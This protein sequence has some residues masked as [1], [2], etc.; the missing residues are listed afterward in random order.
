MKLKLKLFSF[1]MALSLVVGQLF[2]LGNLMVKAADNFSAK[3]IIESSC[4]VIV[5]DTASK[6]NAKDALS[7]VC[8]KHS[9]QLDIS[10]DGFINS[11]NNQAND[12]DKWTKYWM[13]AVNSNDSYPDIN[14]GIDKYTLKNGDKLIAYY[15]GPNTL[16]LNKIDFSTKLSNKPLTISLN[17]SAYGKVTPISNINVKLDGKAVTLS[18]NNIAINNG[19]SLGKHTLD[20]SDYKSDGMPGVVADSINFYFYPQAS[21]RVEGLNSTITTGSSQ[22]ANAEQIVENVLRSNNVSFLLNKYG[23]ISSI[24]NVAEKEYGDG[25]GWMYYVKSK[26]S[27]VSPDKGMLDYVP[28]DGD[29]IVVYYGDYNTTLYVNAITFTPDVFSDNTPFTMKLS[30]NH[31]DWNENKQID[32]PVAN[33]VVTIDDFAPMSTDSN[34]EIKLLSGLTKGQHRYTI[35]GYNNGKV[36]SVVYDKGIFT[37]DGVHSPSFDYSD[38]SYD[39]QNTLADNSSITKNVD[40]EISYTSSYIKGVSDAWAAVSLSKLG[41]KPDETFIKDAADNIKNN[42]IDSLYNTELEKLIIGLVACGYNPNKF[43]GYDL[44]AQLYNRDINKFYANDVIFGL[45][46]YNYA[47]LKGSYAITKDK[48][49]NLLLKDKLSYKLGDNQIEGWTYYGNSIDPDLTGAALSALAPYKDTNSNVKSTIN[50]VVNSLSTLQNESGYV[51]G[52]YGISSESLSFVT[53]GLTAVGV[54]PETGNFKKSKGDLVSA[55]V[56]FKGTDGQYKH[57]L[58]GKNDPL[59]TEQAL[60]AFISIKNFKTLGAYN[61][62]VS[63]IDTKELK[64]FSISNGTAAPSEV[65][66]QTGTFADNEMLILT[67]IIFIVMGTVVIFNKKKNECR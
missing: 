14:V 60:R 38:S 33:A 16:T 23:Y 32:T 8:G 45:I 65:L 44:P 4:G 11:I 39:A 10:D 25:S 13:Y 66:P 51:P 29:E 62:Y 27:I 42:G 57:S 24:N 47:N 6:S 5:S 49:V 64:A 22:G 40:G 20:V 34:G 1:F 7:E 21:V 41:I 46:A 17:N 54:N 30:C 26:N 12:T 50:N 9:I 31:F 63:S 15:A 36:P 55:L 37:I 53:I 61:Y 67:G 19:L 3:V 28:Q 43:N 56:S 48:L 35:S 2:G 18:G 59:A 52:P 58:D